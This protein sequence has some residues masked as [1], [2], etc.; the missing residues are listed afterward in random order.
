MTNSDNDL[1]LATG[2]LSAVA[3]QILCAFAAGMI[4]LAGFVLTLASAGAL[5]GLI[6]LSDIDTFAVS[7]A[8][9]IAILMLLASILSALFVFFGQLR[10]V[11]AS[12]GTGDPFIPENARR[13]G[14]MAWLLVAVQVLA[15]PV[16][17]LR[18]YLANRV[19]GASPGGEQLDFSIFDLTGILVAIVLFILARVF[20]H[21]A[22][23]RDDLEGTV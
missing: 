18:L 16:G 15:V 3:I 14:V 2:R 4:I 5:G 8:A 9:V 1:L 19:E 21:G 22:A 6:D 11:I 12:V 13:L 7:P 10:A 23:M 20:R 17:A